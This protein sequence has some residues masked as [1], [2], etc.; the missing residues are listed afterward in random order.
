MLGVAQAGKVL[1]L[2]LEAHDALAA[3][4]L[5]DLVVGRDVLVGVQLGG[6]GEQFDDLAPLE[7][8]VQ[9]AQLLRLV[10]LR[11]VQDAVQPGEGGGVDQHAVRVPVHVG[12]G[13]RLLEARPVRDLEAHR[14]Q[15]VH[16]ARHEGP[17][18][19]QDVGPEL[20]GLAHAH[21][22]VLGLP[23]RHHLVAHLVQVAPVVLPQELAHVGLAGDGHALVLDG[24]LAHFAVQGVHEQLRDH[25]AGGVVTGVLRQLEAVLLLLDREHPR[26]VFGEDLDALVEHV[27]LANGELVAVGEAAQYVGQRVALVLARQQ[28]PAGEPLI[29]FGRDRGHEEARVG[30]HVHVVHSMLGEGVLLLR[31]PAPGPHRVVEHSHDR[32]IQ[33]HRVHIRQEVLH[34]LEGLAAVLALEVLAVRLHPPPV[35]G[36]LVKVVQLARGAQLHLLVLGNR[37]PKVLLGGGGQREALEDVQPVVG[38]ELGVALGEALLQHLAVD[39]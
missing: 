28:V 1:V 15:F 36:P 3:D 19:G 7:L 8:I 32:G 23:H 2:E 20:H 37:A 30:D 29:A 9:H 22:E 27:R 33:A 34:L 24:L 16:E 10:H 39:L 4:L 31:Q 21:A 14:V 12:V 18:V 35:V 17:A 6:R 25:P 38:Q 11:V 13:P 5:V 26:D